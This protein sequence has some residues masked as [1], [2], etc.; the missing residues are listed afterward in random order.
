VAA[1]AAA[2]ADAVA[3]HAAAEKAAATIAD[4]RTQLA[5]AETSKMQEIEALTKKQKEEC[6]KIANR[7]RMR[8][9]GRFS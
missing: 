3:A 5:E 7:E 9:D 4:L 2:R 1:A 6:E 8:Y